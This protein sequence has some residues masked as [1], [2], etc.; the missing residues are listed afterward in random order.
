MITTSIF[1]STFIDILNTGINKHNSFF[2]SAWS[3]LLPGNLSQIPICLQGKASSFGS[4]TH[5]IFIKN[6]IKTMLMQE[7]SK[8]VSNDLTIM[9]NNHIQ[10]QK[11]WLLLMTFPERQKSLSISYHSLMQFAASVGS[12]SYPALQ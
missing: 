5:L 9:R 4:W 7:P 12:V 10:S 11:F 6:T 8:C 2:W 1:I 3:W